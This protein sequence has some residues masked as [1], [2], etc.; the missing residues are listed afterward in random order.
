MIVAFGI[1]SHACRAEG[2]VTLYD[3]LI[4]IVVSLS[5]FFGLAFLGLMRLCEKVSKHFGNPVIWMEEPAEN[6]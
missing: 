5:S 3:V 6:K 4:A 1:S 2:R